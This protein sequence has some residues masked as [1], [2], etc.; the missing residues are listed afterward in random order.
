MTAMAVGGALGLAGR[1][2]DEAAVTG[3]ELKA[4]TRHFPRV[5]SVASARQAR[6]GRSPGNL[7][8]GECTEE[9]AGP[10]QLSLWLPPRAWTAK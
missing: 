1:E 8:G 9:Q 7:P 6:F 10:Q 3:R 2:A 5:L 4:G